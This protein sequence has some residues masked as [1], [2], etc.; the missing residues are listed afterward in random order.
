MSQRC[1]RGETTRLLVIT[2][3]VVTVEA[4]VAYNMRWW[5]IAPPLFFSSCCCA[6][7][8]RSGR[9][10]EHH[11]ETD[12]VIS[13]CFSYLTC[14]ANSGGHGTAFQGTSTLR[15]AHDTYAPHSTFHLHTFLSAE[16]VDDTRAVPPPLSR[17]PSFF[18]LCRSRLHAKLFFCC[19][20]SSIRE[21]GHLS[22][23]VLSRLLPEL[24]PPRVSASSLFDCDCSLFS[25]S[26]L[27]SFALPF[28][29]V[30]R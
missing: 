4:G 10:A 13:A 20:S 16:R 3:R 30:R 25:F 5:G 27:P 15:T 1:P 8:L 26:F 21:A 29:G 22:W 9:E 2:W 11:W 28:V 6:V 19:C 12:F 23:W 17:H 14:R 24:S 7:V 18:F